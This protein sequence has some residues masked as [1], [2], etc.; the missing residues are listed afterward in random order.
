MKDS[1]VEIDHYQVSKYNQSAPGDVFYSQK[2]PQTGRIV[3]TLSD[4]LGSGIKAGVLATLTATMITKFILNNIPIKESAETIM[5]T[6]PVSKEKGISYATFTSVDIK[7]DSEVYIV[8]YDNP[9][10]ILL[11]DDHVYEPPKEIIPFARKHKET[12]PQI[13]TRLYY[14][15]FKAKPN[16]RIIFFSDGVTQAGLGKPNLEG[17]WGRDAAQKFILETVNANTGISARDLSRTLIEEALRY[18]DY[19]AKDDTSCEVVYFRQPRDLLVM[20]G[21]PWQ[22]K[23]DKVFAEIWNNF[24]GKKIIAGGT[25]AKILERE[26]NLTITQKDNQDNQGFPAESEMKGADMVSEG[27]LTLAD[28]ANVLKHGS[29]NKAAK[30]KTATRMIEMFLNCDRIHFVVGTK[31]NDANYD[32]SIPIE[33]E[34]RRSVVRGIAD[35]LQK[36]YLK[37]VEIRFF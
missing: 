31:I 19:K 14:S 11:R 12:G 4:G 10:Y 1:F 23:N 3:T 34:I 20:T 24:S 26:L 2:D 37:G 33:L 29:K 27:I 7:Q 16:D 28:V 18:H 35:I 15:F 8:E 5:N 25:T 32:P 13:P 36:K 30:N 9:P 6:L 21:P 22:D 17:G